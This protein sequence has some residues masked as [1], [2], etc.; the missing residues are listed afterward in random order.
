MFYIMLLK[1]SLKIFVKFPKCLS[2]A[3]QSCKNW[4]G[5]T[6]NF[7]IILKRCI[8]VAR[9]LQFFRDFLPLISENWMGK[10]PLCPPYSVALDLLI[11][12]SYSFIKSIRYSNIDA[13]CTA[14]RPSQ[15][16]T[17]WTCAYHKF[18]RN[19]HEPEYF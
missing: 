7:D 9:S 1:T 14:I 11:F 3:A 2:G 10:C 6:S 18:Y 13:L 4:V 17:P 8:Q 15:N 5:M 16:I 12:I 19:I